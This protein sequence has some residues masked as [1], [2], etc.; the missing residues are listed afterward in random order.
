MN[1]RETRDVFNYDLFKNIE[2]TGKYNSPV[3]RQCDEFPENVISFNYIHTVKE[4]EKY[5]VHFYI[6]DYQFE[7]VWNKAKLY[8]KMLKKFAGVIGPDFSAYTDMSLSQR[9]W[10][11]YRNKLLMAYWQKNGIK[12]IPNVRWVD[13]CG[14]NDFNNGLDGYP[15]NS[16]IAITTN[17]FKS[18]PEEIYNKA[19]NQVIQ[20]LK[21]SMVVVIGTLPNKYK[22]LLEA[23]KI[24]IKEFKSRLDI[25]GY[26]E[27]KYA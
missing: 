9:I 18:T 20:Q 16:T 12:V 25:L 2:I 1:Y 27:V 11:V 23:E 21:P 4:P 22:Q 13:N 26:K 8:V 7:R 14:L 24:A 15:Q 6:D 5:F 17:G 10:N 3:I 19:F